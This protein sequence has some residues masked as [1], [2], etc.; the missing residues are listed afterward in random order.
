M[1]HRMGVGGGIV[2]TIQFKRGDEYLAKIAR[3]EAS[4]KSQVLGE[5]I[6][7]AAGIV[8]DEI[9]SSLERVP[10]DEG[11]GTRESPTRGPTAYQVRGLADSLGIASMQDDGTGYLNVKIGFDGYNGI[12]T[13]R[14]PNGQPNQ[15]VARSV[16]SGTTW[17]KKNPFVRKAVTAS[18][19]RAV[20]Y[21]K[22]SVDRSI[23]EIME[24]D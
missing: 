5:A 16:E 12:K 9:R 14:W 18:R 7:G 21:M 2:A 8:A 4:L 23:E 1:A 13:Q 20:E 24:G 17:M 19:K 3:L 6:Y 15:M 11:Y 10:T 22:N